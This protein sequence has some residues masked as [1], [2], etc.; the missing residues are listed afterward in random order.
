[1]GKKWL[2][3]RRKDPYYK[4]A[5]R[6][7]YRSRASYKLKQINNRFDLVRK[8]HTIIE[9]GSSPGGWTQVLCELVGDRGKV[10]AIDRDP[11]P[12]VEGAAFILA[13][14][15][16]DETK[17]RVREELDGSKAD[18]VVSDMSP[19]ISGNYSMDQAR[20]VALAQL[21]LDYARE[22]LKQGGGIVVKVFEGEDFH[23]FLKEVRDCFDFVKVHSPKASRK[24]S[25][26]VYVVGKGYKD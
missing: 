24:S 8:G 2:R 22:F 12:K 5:K 19:N 25:S 17:K 21:T 14:A 20:S 26:E 23:A 3:K 7:G 10:I 4:K 13:D 15:E 6:E 11:M 16:E 1:M 9:L 18:L